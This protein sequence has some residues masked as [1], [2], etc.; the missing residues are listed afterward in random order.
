[1]ARTRK[2][3]EYAEKRQEIL[4][5][6]RR[7]MLERG[8]E[9]ITIQ[10]LLSELKI[11]SG[12]F[13]HYFSSRQALLEGLVESML[14]DSLAPLLPIVEARDL[15]ALQK[16]QGWFDAIDRLRS[17]NQRFLVDMLR[18]WY[19]DDNAIVHQKSEKVL[20]KQRA[21]LLGAI[22]R[23]GMEEGIFSTTHPERAGEI[24]L[25]LQ[26]AMGDTH[27]GFLLQ[28]GRGG[29]EGEVIEG[30]LSSHAATME[31]IERVLG[32]PNGSL[33]RVEAQEVRTWVAALREAS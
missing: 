10:D 17:G 13:Y 4:A 21:P 3:Q 14:E 33:R 11:S 12:A 9:R 7:L 31:A 28:L 20:L 1:M 8:Y 19:A 6:A 16:L 30:I 2:E 24:L 29:G 27:A 22:V 15:S 32:A 5:V 26:Q 25:A 23:Q 18:S